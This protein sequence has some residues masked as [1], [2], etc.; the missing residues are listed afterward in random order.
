MSKLKFIILSTGNAFWICRDYLAI[1]RFHVAH[2]EICRQLGNGDGSGSELVQKSFSEWLETRILLLKSTTVLMQHKEAPQQ[3][4][5]GEGFRI[6]SGTC[7]FGRSQAPRQ[8]IASETLSC[9]SRDTIGSPCHGAFPESRGLHSA[10][11]QLCCEQRVEEVHLQGTTVSIPAP[12]IIRKVSFLAWTQVQAMS[13][14]EQEALL[15]ACCSSNYSALVT[16]GMTGQ[17]E[18]GWGDCY[19]PCVPNPQ[20]R[21]AK[22]IFWRAQHTACKTDPAL[23]LYGTLCCAV[24]LI[25]R[26]VV[27]SSLF[28]ASVS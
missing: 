28:I 13:W 24:V 11:L 7:F 14:Y 16:S 4:L 22:E 10:L 6:Q 21:W 2:C 3:R 17:W 19:Q 26:S 20:L 1:N 15:G 25:W 8:P 9:I 23:L 27:H 5:C 12:F 18:C